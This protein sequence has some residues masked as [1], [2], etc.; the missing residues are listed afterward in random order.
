M[1]NSFF[2]Y[3]LMTTDVEA[4]ARFYGAVVGW[5]AQDSGVPDSHYTLLTL[6]SGRGVAGLMPIP[7]DARKMGAGPAWMGYIAV[8]DVAEAGARLQR[9]GGTLHKGPIEIPGVI[10]FSVVADPQGAGFIIAK[11]LI[12]DAPPAL[13]PGTAGT[14]G[15]HELYAVDGATAFPFYERLFGW[16]KA[17]AFDMGPMGS[18]QLFKTGVEAVGG[19]MTKPQAVPRPFWGYY[20]NVP[21][22]DAAV[23]R[24]TTAGGQILNGP[25][26]VPGGQWIIQGLDP[27]G[28][29]F[30]LVAPRR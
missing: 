20:I 4:A 11:G 3:D 10:R 8:E 27:Q 30:A 15:W 5:G 16:T 2:W 21:A 6:D 9:E 12:H 17:E 24:V 28:A 14:V 26:E 7:E 23:T 1:P 18:Y 22:I 13:P 19:I 25:M 29:F